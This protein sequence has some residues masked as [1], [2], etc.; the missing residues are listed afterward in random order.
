MPEPS[1]DWLA[2]INLLG[3]VQGMFLALVFLTVKKGNQTANR[4]LGVLLL[5]FAF[6]VFEIFLGYTGYIRYVPVLVN[7]EEPV[8][9]L[10]GPLTYFYTLALLRPGFHFRWEKSIGYILFPV[11]FSL[12][13]GRLSICN[14]MPIN[15]RIQ[16]VPFIKRMHGRCMQKKYFIF[17]NMN[18]WWAFGW[19]S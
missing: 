14:Q 10:I 9:F 11:S 13:A 12:Q 8:V 4:L 3:I 6:V 1:L 18:F 7:L 2:I 15:F 5:V 19:T 16:R 17:P